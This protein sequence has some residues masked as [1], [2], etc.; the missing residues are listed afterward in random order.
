[1]IDKSGSDLNSIRSWYSFRRPN[2]NQSELTWIGNQYIRDQPDEEAS[3]YPFEHA[4]IQEGATLAVDPTSFRLHVHIH[5]W[6]R[7]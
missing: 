2:G 1:M 4:D 3:T 7:A 5:E 6:V